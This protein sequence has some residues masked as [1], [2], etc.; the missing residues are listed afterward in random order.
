MAVDKL[1]VDVILLHPLAF[2][3]RLFL[4]GMLIVLILLL[5]KPLK[6]ML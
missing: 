6:Q 3:Y 5:A 4:F 2:R 1:V